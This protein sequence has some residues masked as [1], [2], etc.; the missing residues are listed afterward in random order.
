MRQSEKLRQIGLGVQLRALRENAGLSTR[1]VAKSLGVSASSVNRN[2]LG[3][4]APSKE[5]VSALCALYGVVG[6]DKEALLEKV[7]DSAET[8]AWLANGVPDQL[9]S[10]MVLER[11][12]VA[13]TDVQVSVMPGLAQTAD[14]ARLVLGDQAEPGIDLENKVATRLGRQAVLSK[15]RA[16]RV[17]CFIDEGVLHRTLGNSRVLRDQL[18]QLII[19]QRRDNVEVR[20]IPFD[21]TPSSSIKASFSAYELVSGS[22][23]VFAEV[24]NLGLFVTD[25][26]E[27]RSFMKVCRSLDESA[28]DTAESSVLIRKIAESLNDD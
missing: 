5:E 24:Y 25:P 19:L 27:V 8:A 15:P 3:L 9:A 26:S 18:E 21:W 2:E 23:Y 16:P 12:A 6:E 14:Y 22:P 28:L 11:E 20:V 7:G 10:L 1:S 17:S 13:I 4:R